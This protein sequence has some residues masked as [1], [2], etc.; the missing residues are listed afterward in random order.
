M[1]KA[2][3]YIQ[4]EIITTFIWENEFCIILWFVKYQLTSQQKFKSHSILF[5]TKVKL[6]RKSGM[7]SKVAKFDTHAVPIPFQF[8]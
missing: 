8:G 6:S 4:I 2:K 5:S 3:F 1:T 7:L